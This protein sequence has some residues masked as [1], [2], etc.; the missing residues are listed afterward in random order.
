[1]KIARHDIVYYVFDIA[2]FFAWLHTPE[3][4]SYQLVPGTT[5]GLAVWEYPIKYGYYGCEALLV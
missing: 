4:R 2:I 3:D 1:M 5:L